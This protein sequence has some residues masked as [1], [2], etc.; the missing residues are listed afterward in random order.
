M[1]AT[2]EPIATTTLGSAAAEITFSSIGST[3]TDLR[4]SFVTASGTSANTAYIRFNGDTATNY[5]R[6]SIYGNG[7]SALSNQTS[8]AN[9]IA[10]PTVLLASTP[11]FISCDVFSYAGS[12]YKTCL[13]T[14]NSDANGSGTVNYLVGLWRST[15]AITSLTL[16]NNGGT[17]ATGTTA[18]LYGIKNA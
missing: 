18:T 5:S 10:L 6:T 17:F 1:P 2:Y 12:T 15:S 11:E 3:Y 13:A 4:V 16:G 9:R 8:T 14:Q 7:T